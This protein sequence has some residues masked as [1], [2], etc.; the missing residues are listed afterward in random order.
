[1]KYEAWMRI[2]WEDG[3]KTYHQW[4]YGRIFLSLLIQYLMITRSKINQ[5]LITTVK[6]GVHANSAALCCYCLDLR[7]FPK[8]NV[9]KA[10]S[11]HW[12]YWEVMETLRN[13]I[14]WKVFRSLRSCPWKGEWD[15]Q[16][17]SLP[18]FLCPDHKVLPGIA[19]VMYCLNPG[20]KAIR[21]TNPGLILPKRWAKINLSSL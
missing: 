14:W 13:E 18:F 8:S 7:C 1:M 11:P 9:L 5:H 15:P 10:W 21:S 16:P 4:E 20:P 3:G 12:H 2:R 17:L 19:T 6:Q